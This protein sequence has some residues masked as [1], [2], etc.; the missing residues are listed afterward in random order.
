MSTEIE[1]RE[2]PIFEV[3]GT[4]EF[5]VCRKFFLST[6][7]LALKMEQGKSTNGNVLI[8]YVLNRE[9]KVKCLNKLRKLYGVFTEYKYIIIREYDDIE[10]FHNFFINTGVLALNMEEGKSGTDD[11]ITFYVLNLNDKCKVISNIH[12]LYRTFT[13]YRYIRIAEYRN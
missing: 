3:N 12:K 7:V 5:Y 10:I 4:E 8:F 11:A 13:K 1:S 2:L 9:D 6:E